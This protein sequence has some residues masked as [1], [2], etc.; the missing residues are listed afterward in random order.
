M[1]AFKIFTLNVLFFPQLSELICEVLFLI[2]AFPVHSYKY[3]ICVIRDRSALGPTTGQEPGLQAGPTVGGR[4]GDEQ[5]LAELPYVVLRV[6][7]GS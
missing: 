1:R 7:R 3:F 6:R 4:R 2:F 5:T